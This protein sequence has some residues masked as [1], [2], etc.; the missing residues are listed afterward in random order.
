MIIYI[1]HNKIRPHENII[2]FRESLFYG[3]ENKF[4]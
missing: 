1:I 4:S 3:F 2:V